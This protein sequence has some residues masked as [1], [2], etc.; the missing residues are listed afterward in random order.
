MGWVGGSHAHGFALPS[1]CFCYFFMIAISA[2]TK[3]FQPK[4]KK[5]EF[6]L[7]VG[8]QSACHPATL[9]SQTRSKLGLEK[10]KRKHGLYLYFDRTRPHFRSIRWSIIIPSSCFRSG[11]WW[12][13][14][15]RERAIYYLQVLN[16][17]SLCFWISIIYLVIDSVD[18][19]L[20]SSSFDCYRST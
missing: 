3:N 20:S 15:N 2:A 17:V 1:S 6:S 8:C 14:Y 12:W 9:T 5:T 4:R 16:F 19:L 7:V 11:F 10:G 18:L 13:W